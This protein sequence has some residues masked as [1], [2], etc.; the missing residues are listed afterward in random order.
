MTSFIVM[1]S[2]NRVVVGNESKQRQ[3][4]SLALVRDIIEQAQDKQANMNFKE[5]VEYYIEALSAL[6]SLP[7]DTATSLLRNKAYIGVA[8]VFMDCEM[9]EAAKETCF[10]ALDLCVKSND[11]ANIAVCYRKIGNLCYY[12]SETDNPDTLLHYLQKSMPY[13]KG[14]DPYISAFYITL[15]AGLKDRETTEEF[16]PK[17]IKGITLLP[18]EHEKRL[19]YLE[20]YTAW[21]LWISNEHDKAI[22]YAKRNANSSDLRL[23]ISSLELLNVFYLKTCDTA[24]AVGTRCRLDSIENLLKEEKRKAAGIENAFAQYEE[25]RNGADGSKSLNIILLIA[26]IV[27]FVIAALLFARKRKGEKTSTCNVDKL[28]SDFKNSG[29]CVKIAEKCESEKGL[30]A[31]NV[32]ASNIRLTKNEIMELEQEVN[33]S[34]SSFANKFHEMHPD[35]NEGEWHYILVT[36]LK[37]NEVE[38][39]ALLGLSYQGCTSR[40]KR[41][42]EKLKTTN[43]NEYLRKMLENI[44]QT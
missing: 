29:I 12:L 6:D 37:T 26:L 21:A 18:A 20:N 34:F 32:A 1:L 7:T 10:K 23:K 16:M 24:M 28:L 40:R 3:Q 2:P 4:F 44:T 25:S 15:I 42:L 35:I 38:K 27:L 22:S 31:A 11:S 30:T 33:N 41:V 43:L 17:R 5:A 9:Y 36:L 39:S 13:A 14:E 19:P 8:D